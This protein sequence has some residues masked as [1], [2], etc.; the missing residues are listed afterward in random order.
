MKLSVADSLAAI[1][2]DTVVRFAF[3]DSEPDLASAP[4]AVREAFAAGRVPRKVND[5]TSLWADGFVTAIVGLGER[6]KLT[7]LQW[8][9]ACG[10]AARHLEARGAKNV[11]VLPPDLAGIAPDRALSLLS[12]GVVIGLH[13]NGLYKSKD[14]ATNRTESWTIVTNA[15]EAADVVGK[16]RAVAESANAARDLINAAP[17]ELTP[18]ELAARAAKAGADAGLVVRVLKAP[19]LETIGAQGLLTV[20]KGSENPPTMTVMEYLPNPGQAPVV[21]VGK[22]ITFDSGGI[23]LKPG[24]GMHDMK[25]DMSGAAAVFGAM[26]AV[27]RTK[28]PVNV[29]GILVAAEN[30]PGGRAY[31]PSD[32]IR[33]ANGKNVEVTNTDAE[34]RLILADGLIYGEREYSPRSIVEL[35]T[36]TGSCVIALGEDMSG[37]FTSDDSLAQGLLDAADDSTDIAWRMPMYEPY[38]SK[39]D[40]PVA[41]FRNAQSDRWGGSITAALFLQ[42]FVEKTPYA[43][44]DIAGPAYDE[45]ERAYIAPGGTG[46]GVSLLMSYIGGLADREA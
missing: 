3:S 38:K 18:E 41:D 43:H 46:Y 16:A 9:R 42:E 25:G 35:S 17:N 2:P 5:I 26:L 32:I 23:N 19:E 12:L 1:S 27:A 33:Y 30:L 28:P 6:D 14:E 21:L 44:V 29:V 45:T 24:A 31:R 40:S 11:A 34:G 36:L 13:R 39:H 8:K 15:P 4:T 37:V 22:G 10:A 7:A 20:G